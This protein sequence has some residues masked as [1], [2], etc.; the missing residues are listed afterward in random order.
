MY[1]LDSCTVS[2]FMKGEIAT[3]KKIKSLSPSLMYTSTITQLEIKYGLLRKFNSSHKY[4][5]I[6]EDFMTVITVLPFEEEAANCSA[7]IMVE[8]NRKGIPIGAY[9]ILIG[10]IALASGL[11]LVTS[12]KKEFERIS[13][14]NIENWRVE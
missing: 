4:F 6:F 3:A 13:H 8:L 10:G 11:T 2:D 7:K 1:L 5:K 14:L 12:N 9:D